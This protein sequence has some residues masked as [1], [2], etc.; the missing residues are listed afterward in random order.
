MPEH[1]PAMLESNSKTLSN[2][3]IRNIL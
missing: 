1:N 2:Q 3:L